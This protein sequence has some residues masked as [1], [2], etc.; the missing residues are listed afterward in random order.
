VLHPYDAVLCDLRMP[1]M[2]GLTLLR[3]L[4]ELHSDA[5]VV[6]MTAHADVRDAIEALREGV[7]DFLIKPMPMS[8]LCETLRKIHDVRAA[9]GNLRHGD[10]GPRRRDEPISMP[11]VPVEV[12]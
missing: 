1:R 12:V 4:R 7:F 10:G 5:S 6:L 3:R 8:E 9:A 2:D 11:I